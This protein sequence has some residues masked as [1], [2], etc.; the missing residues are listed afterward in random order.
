MN[1]TQKI[2]KKVL[3]RNYLNFQLEENAIHTEHNLY[4]KNTINNFRESNEELNKIFKGASDFNYVSVYV[5]GSWADNTKT[6][7]SDLDDLIIINRSELRN[8]PE[9]IKKLTKWLK[10]V[11]MTFCKIDL[12]QHHG[13]WIIYQ[14][15]LNNY[16][17]SYMPL[18][19]LKNSVLIHGMDEI[20]YKIDDEKTK[21]GLLKN[22]I[23]TENNIK[24]WAKKY[25]NQ[26]ITSYDMKCL[27]GSF[28]LMPAYAFQYKGYNI[29]KRE[30]IERKQEIFSKNTCIFL[31]KC[32]DIRYH[33][34]I[35]SRK[36]SYKMLKAFSII[37]ND[38]DLFRRISKRFSPVFPKHEFVTL[39]KAEIDQFLHEIASL[40]KQ[41][42]I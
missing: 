22:I 34:N 39:E 30:A 5:H 33:W 3:N 32:S 13:H 1:T 10:K 38:A 9:E 27:I 36:K 2:I 35:I 7:F 23:T 18:N 15:L 11:D 12:L 21:E 37:C 24:I 6:F 29:S 8:Q 16:D 25:I 19:V 41:Q 31:D 42:T 14:D 40:K 26:K 4:P 28:L 20:Y 17:E